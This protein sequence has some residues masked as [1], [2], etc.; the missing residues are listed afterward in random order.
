MLRLQE[1][2]SEWIKFT[3]VMA[4]GVNLMLWLLWRGE[5]LSET[6]LMITVCSGILSILIAILKPRWFRGFYRVGMTLS[7][8]I[9]QF[10][11]KLILV[12]LFFLLVT[13][14]GLLLRL[15]GKDLLDMRRQPEATTYWKPARS[16]REFD[17][18]F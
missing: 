2:P 18:M 5:L 14:L 8:E 15:L 13:P 11:G 6:V 10:F 17:R 9:G 4:F 12:L 7:F 1:K 16:S 3:A